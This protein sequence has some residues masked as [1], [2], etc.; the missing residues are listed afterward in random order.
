M[1]EPKERQGKTNE[2]IDGFKAFRTKGCLVLF[3]YRSTD[4]SPIV[5][6]FGAKKRG[7]SKRD[8]TYI[9]KARSKSKL[10]IA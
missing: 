6:H 5:R 8:S 2:R 9:V 10:Y 7:D 4:R 1:G 3:G